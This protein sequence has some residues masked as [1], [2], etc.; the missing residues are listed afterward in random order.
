MSI[1]PNAVMAKLAA[2]Y[3]PDSPLWREYPEFTAERRASVA[4]LAALDRPIVRDVCFRGARLK[5]GRRRIYLATAGAPA[6][7]KTTVLEQQIAADPETYGD[8][9]RADPDVYSM[10][11]MV[12]TYHDFLLSPLLVA[13]SPDYRSAQRRAYDIARPWSNIFAN[14]VINEAI[15]AGFSLAHGTTMTGGSV[16]ELLTS[17]REAGC[18][19]HLLLCYAPDRV[20]DD[21]A[22]YRATV[23]GNY[24]ATAQDVHAKGR[25]FPQRFASYF[26][27]ADRLTLFWRTGVTDRACEAAVYA[28]GKACVVDETAFDHFR[29]KYEDDCRALGRGDSSGGLDVAL[30]P[31]AELEALYSSRF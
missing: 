21:S 5:E 27:L 8:L 26:S 15:G 29:T 7:G 3:E 1:I 14:E 16:R 19:V 12:H 20:R 2:E 13:E 31:F 23:Q 10:R 22:S 18:E 11:S 30:T 9:V 25:L 17:I 4:R 6:A 28:Q 24:Q